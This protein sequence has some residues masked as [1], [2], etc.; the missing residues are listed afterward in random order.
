[1]AILALLGD[2]SH[3]RSS[4][5]ARA[6]KIPEP[7]ELTD[8]EKLAMGLLMTDPNAAN[9]GAW[10]YPLH[11]DLTY[12]G[13]TDAEATSVL[14]AL[15]RK[16]AIEYVEVDADDPPSGQNDTA[17]AYRLTPVGAE[18]AAKHAEVQQSQ[19][20]Y[21]YLTRVTGDKRRNT[22]LLKGVLSLQ[23]VQ[24]QTRFI[25]SGD[26]KSS[27]I[28]IWSYVAQDESVLRAIAVSSGSKI[29]SI[30]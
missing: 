25:D 23:K 11:Q 30:D 5:S 16:K 21:T 28:K 6:E 29:I 3:R 26:S 9:R 27:L 17:P 8:N 14:A 7:I 24:R 19:H 22:A 10:L 1:M 4:V 2:T 18:L 12:R 13:L 15:V 20:V